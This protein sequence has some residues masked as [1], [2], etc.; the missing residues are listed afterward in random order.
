MYLSPNFMDMAH[1]NAFVSN[2]FLLERSGHILS[3]STA[4]RETFKTPNLPKPQVKTASLG[5]AGKARS[6]L[7]PVSVPTAPEASE[8]GHKQTEDPAN[9]DAHGQVKLLK[10]KVLEKHGSHH[11]E[12]LHFSSSS[13][14]SSSST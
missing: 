6:P 11:K 14:F 3:S 10:Q 2:G 4:I 12:Q 5:L 13:S 8:E 7:L 9:L 1:L